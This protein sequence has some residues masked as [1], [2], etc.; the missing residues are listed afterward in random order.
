MPREYS[1]TDTFFERL[2]FGVLLALLCFAPLA[3]GAVRAV[4]FLVVQGATILLLL[5][6]AARVWFS[7]GTRLLWPPVF[8]T[9]RRPAAS[10]FT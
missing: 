9:P 10:P 3:T 6:W 1:D 7:P 5:I 8:K 2:F 4:D